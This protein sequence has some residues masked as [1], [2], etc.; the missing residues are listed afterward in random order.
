M[1]IWHQFN[2]LWELM[3]D[4]T[5][6]VVV[7]LCLSTN[8]NHFLPKVTAAIFCAPTEWN[9]PTTSTYEG[10]TWKYTKIGNEDVFNHVLWYIV[11]PYEYT[12]LERRKT[13][14]RRWTVPK[15]TPNGIELPIHCTAAVAMYCDFLEFLLSFWRCLTVIP[16]TLNHQSDRTHCTTP[17]TT[18]PTPS[19]G[20][21]L[22]LLLKRR[23]VW[24]VSLDSTC[25][26]SG[27]PW[28]DR[29]KISERVPVKGL[30]KGM[31]CTSME[32][33]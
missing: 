9:V 14:Q 22:S 20:A 17:Q 23:L 5:V 10:K 28:K 6:C 30:Q 4:T 7:L 2:R 11:E 1:I 8:F 33:W 21:M 27:D 16:Q 19:S 25:G 26:D 18:T 3:F 15:Y 29:S 32:V 24:M 13:R 31:N 12:K